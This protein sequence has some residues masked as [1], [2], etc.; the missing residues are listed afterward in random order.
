MVLRTQ[1]SEPV[2]SEVFNPALALISC[3]TL[4]ELFLFFVYF[5]ISKFFIFKSLIYLLERE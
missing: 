3:V 5:F 4:G 2:C 1:A